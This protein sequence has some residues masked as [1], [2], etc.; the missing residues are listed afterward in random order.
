MEEPI[1]D[2]VEQAWDDVSG[3]ELDQKLVRQARIEE[4]EYIHKMKLY[5]KVNKKDCYMKIGKAFITVKWID[6]NKGDA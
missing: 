6:I 4:V 1:N 3:A 5:E 2:M